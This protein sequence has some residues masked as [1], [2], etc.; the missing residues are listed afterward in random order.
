MEQSAV[1][2]FVPGCVSV[3]APHPGFRKKLF[4]LCF[5]PLSTEAKWLERGGVA[6]GA[7][8]RDLHVKTTEVA[9]QCHDSPMPG[10]THSAIAATY[11]MTTAAAEKK[12]G[13]TASINEQERLVAG[14]KRIGQGP[15]KRNRN[16]ILLSLVPHINDYNLWQGAPLDA[17]RQPEQME[18]PL[19]SVLI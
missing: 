15:T 7:Q 16:Q 8:R 18:F 3:H 11:N 2:L 4:H 14:R 6:L 10:K 17:M 12:V 13:E 5:N 19:K 9:S 1:C